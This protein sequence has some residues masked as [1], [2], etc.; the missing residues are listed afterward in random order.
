MYG[1]I[2]ARL[3]YTWKADMSLTLPA[4]AGLCTSFR[5]HWSIFTL[6]AYAVNAR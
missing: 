4:M 3:R 2:F 1:L 5:R 6:I